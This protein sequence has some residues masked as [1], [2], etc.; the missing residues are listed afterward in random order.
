MTHLAE[1]PDYEVVEFRRAADST[2]IMNPVVEEDILGVVAKKDKM[3]ADGLGDIARCFSEPA[4]VVDALAGDDDPTAFL[5]KMWFEGFATQGRSLS[6]HHNGF[7]A[8]EAEL[9]LE[10]VSVALK[11]MGAGFH[12]DV[13]FWMLSSTRRHLMGFMTVSGSLRTVSG[14]PR[15]T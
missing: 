15:W 6:A 9:A 12:V 13:G 14:L 8:Y 4:R 2:G 11:L 10:R 3:I 5:S 7:F 1:Y